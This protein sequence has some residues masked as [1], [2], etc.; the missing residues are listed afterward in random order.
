MAHFNRYNIDDSLKVDVQDG[1]DDLDALV[2]QTLA[3]QQDSADASGRAL[4]KA[5]EVQGIA[6]SSAAKLDSQ[7]ASIQR[8]DHKLDVLGTHVDNADKKTKVLGK[9][10][11]APFWM[12]VFGQNPKDKAPPV[13]N[14]PNGAP[15]PTNSNGVP[16]YQPRTVSKD[17]AVIAYGDSLASKVGDFASQAQQEQSLKFE[18]I[19]DS[20]LSELSSVLGGVKSIA[21]EMNS[22][23]VKQNSDLDRLA[24]KADTND[25][26]LGQMNRKLKKDHGV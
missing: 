7:G 10:A 20:N 19:I 26:K 13:F 17:P 22:V 15:I 5:Y 18:K 21:K 12:P 11:N 2:S 23:I 9:L 25:S 16:V 4:K 3:V 1:E 6:I 8:L 24:D 14:M